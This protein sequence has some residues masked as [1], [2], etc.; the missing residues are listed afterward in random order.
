MNNPFSR[1]FQRRNMI[2]STALILQA[3][4][5]AWKNWTV[6][7]AVK[8]GMKENGWVYRAISIIARNAGSIPWSV[9]N[10][11]TNEWE[12]N[13]PLSI[14]LNRPNPQ[15]SRLDMF[16]LLLFWQQLAGRAYL[17]KV[18][19]FQKRTTEL[20]PISPDR[21]A[22]I[23]GR[24]PGVLIEGYATV[25]ENGVVGQKSDPNYPVADVVY[26]RLL[27]PADPISGLSPLEAAAR[28]VDVDSGQQEW[29]LS[30]N[31]NRG[32]LDTIIS[33]KQEITT[34]QHEFAVEKIKERFSGSKNA[35]TPMVL[36][37]EATAQRLGLTP[38]EMDWIES[39]KQNREEIWVIFGIPLQLGSA[40]FT[41]YNNF[42]TARR[43]LW[44]MT[45]I[46]LLEDLA[47]TFNTSFVDELGPQYEIAFDLSNVEALRDN[48]AKRAE[49]AE[50]FWRMG[51]PFDQLNQRFELGID[52]FPGSDQPW[53]GGK[54][55]GNVTT[56]QNVVQPNAQRMPLGRL[57]ERRDYVKEQETRDRLAEGPV[58]STFQTLLD[59]Q[60]KAVEAAVET[61]EDIESVIHSQRSTWLK[62]M[63]AMALEVGTVAAGMVA[64][65]RATGRP[66]RTEVR[67][68]FD[69]AIQTQLEEYLQQ[70]QWM[71]EDL[72]H[73]EKTT[74]QGVVEQIRDGLA[75]GMTTAQIQAAIQDL[76]LFTP[77]RA[78]MLARTLAGTAASIGQL[79]AAQVSGAQK[80][81]WMTS[82]FGVRDAH[83]AREGETVDFTAR[84]SDQGYGAPR[85]PLD[86]T[87]EPAD[88]VNCRCSMTFG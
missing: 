4:V 71:L 73:M 24:D 81:T 30:A 26:F 69:A 49:T 36:G 56:G 40:D 1:F 41:S 84:F 57:L 86:P 22:P 46:P 60:R 67:D 29:N 75:N 63:N 68:E 51:V 55:T 32:V 66:P 44:E 19:G 62:A 65:G 38:A 80:K 48:D 16:Q 10:K 9:R 28:A 2:T 61:G 33:F 85:Y 11:D 88:R 76:G 53:T 15:V 78:L 23:P 64:V 6:R 12:R 34:D 27:D 25:S 52:V 8:E 59:N 20:W 87:L 83:V 79:A 58:A 43:V 37:N 50:R 5:P 13:H 7:H 74:A 3:G 47:D 21:I 77:A 45:L 31:K 42:E 70:E 72:S 14:L 35:R 54:A 39:R 82:L 18:R 17:K